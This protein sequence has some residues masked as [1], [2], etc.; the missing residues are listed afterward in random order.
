LVLRGFFRANTNKNESGSKISGNILLGI[1]NVT[2]DGR[3]KMDRVPKLGFICLLPSWT[4]SGILSNSHASLE[5]LNGW[6][7]SGGV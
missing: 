1:T 3:E 2:R 6:K 5:T 7:T 4:I